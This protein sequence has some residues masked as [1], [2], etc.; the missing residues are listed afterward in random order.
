MRRG[1]ALYLVGSVAL[2]VLAGCGRGWFEQRDPWRS[3]AERACMRSG[4]VKPGAAVVPIRAIDG[5]GVCGAQYPLKVAALGD[6]TILGYMR[7]V[8]PPGN[9]PGGFPIPEPR[10]AAPSPSYNPPP[11]GDPPFEPR[12]SYGEQRAPLS[13][14]PPARTRETCPRRLPVRPGKRTRMPT[15]GDTRRRAIARAAPSGRASARSPIATASR[16]A[17]PNGSHRSMR[18][19]R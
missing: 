13:L 15:T 1:A 10:R 11:A 6:R 12:G 18:R 9:I 19:S 3:E 14:H 5:P 16:P 8:R 4:A 2:L 7:D 17:R